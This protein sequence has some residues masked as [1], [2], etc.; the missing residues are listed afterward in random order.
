M[1]SRPERVT[2]NTEAFRRISVKNHAN[3]IGRVPLANIVATVAHA[4]HNHHI[5]DDGSLFVSK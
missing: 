2:I 1:T 4:Y 3:N 5:R